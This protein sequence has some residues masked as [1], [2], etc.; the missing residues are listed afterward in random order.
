MAAFR[1]V[2]VG[3]RNEAVRGKFLYQPDHVPAGRMESFGQMIERRPSVTLPT[4]EIGQI[5]V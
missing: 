3:Y 1:V 5:G 4:R 2:D